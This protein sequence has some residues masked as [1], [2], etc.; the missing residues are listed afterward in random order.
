ME[1]YHGHMTMEDGSHVPLTAQQAN[2]LWELC[3]HEQR[4]R[5]KRMPDEDA[6]IKAMF[7]AWVRLKELGWGEAMYCPKDGSRFKVIENGSIGIFDCVYEGKWPDG[8]WTT[9][10]GG[11]CYPSSTAPALY[12]LYPEDEEKRKAKMALAAAA[13]QAERDA[14]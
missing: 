8:H 1:K 9:F 10:D 2:E 11:D 6:A 12:R 13:Y 7:D 5:I 14:E 4:E 3:E